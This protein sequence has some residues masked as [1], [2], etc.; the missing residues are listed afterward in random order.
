M[1]R[2]P[3]TSHALGTSKRAYIDVPSYKMSLMTP[4]LEILSRVRP[5]ALQ[6]SREPFPGDQASRRINLE[7]FGYAPIIAALV[8]CL[9]EGLSA[10][11]VTACELSGCLHEHLP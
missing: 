6:G 9:A 11:G 2:C 5:K 3:Y 10:K 7:C 1:R 4:V 8:V